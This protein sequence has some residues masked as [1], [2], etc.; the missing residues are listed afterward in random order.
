MSVKSGQCRFIIKR[1]MIK[2]LF[3]PT[4]N[5]RVRADFKC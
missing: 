5:G 1:G 4:A 2:T 3:R